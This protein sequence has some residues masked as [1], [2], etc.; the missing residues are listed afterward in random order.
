MLIKGGALGL[1]ETLLAKDAP[2]SGDLPAWMEWERQRYALDFARHQWDAIAQR[3]AALPADVPEGFRQ[4]AVTQSVWAKLMAGDGVGAREVLRPLLQQTPVPAEQMAEWR[5]LEIRSYLVDDQLA[6]ARTAIERYQRDYDARGDDWQVLRATLS[7]RAGE[8]RVA[9]Q[10]LADVHSREGQLLAQL[11][12]LR[13]G[14]YPPNAVLVRAQ[15]LTLETRDQ[16]TLQRQAWLLLATAAVAADDLPQIVVGLEHAFTL[17]DAAAPGD[18]VFV[19]PP[20]DLWHAYERAGEAAVRQAHLRL[21][22]DAAALT[23]AASYTRD[24]AVRARNVYGWLAR[25]A[26]SGA[27]RERAQQ[28]LI[29]SLFE[30]GRQKVVRQ[31][32]TESR[33]YATLAALSEPVRYRLFD[34]ALVDYDIAFATRVMQT[35]AAPPAGE[36]TAM[37]RLRRARVLVY[38]GD[39]AAASPMLCQLLGA[40]SPFAADF[41]ERYLQVVFDLQ[42]AGRH[43]QALALLE[44]LYYLVGLPRSQR[45]ILYW[46][47]ESRSALGQHAEAAELYLRSATFAGG[48]GGDLWGQSARFHAAEALGRAGLTQDARGVYQELLKFSD[49]PK[50]RALLQRSIQQLWLTDPNVTTR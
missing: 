34:Q 5:R 21:G 10:Q 12:G 4:W 11:A 20:D 41:N 1:A 33:H 29:D 28:Q 36:D 45:E 49:D 42:T 31:L 44:S 32:F 38:S 30:D 19:A 15:K 3:T 40:V 9:L 50:Q 13:S 8:S 14:A 26:R 47:A 43:D 7:L 48:N 17:Q 24:E 35:L 39:Y 46:M 37:W 23:L 27:T 2:P 25:R 6:A 18:R 22:D 16:P